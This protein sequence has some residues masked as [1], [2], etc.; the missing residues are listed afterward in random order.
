MRECARPRSTSFRRANRRSS[1]LPSCSN[2]PGWPAA[3]YSSGSAPGTRAASGRC[4]V[5]ALTDG[6]PSKT[7]SGCSS[8]PR[9]TSASWRTSSSSRREP[10]RPPPGP[11]AAGLGRPGSRPS[12]PEPMVPP[13]PAGIWLASCRPWPSTMAACPGRRARLRAKLSYTNLG[14]AIAPAEFTLSELRDLYIAALGRRVAATNLQRVLGRR[15]LLDALDR[16]RARRPSADAR[17]TC[18]A[19]AAGASRS[20]IRSPFF[21]RPQ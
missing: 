1:R 16:H 21:G 3:R 6:P 11:V 8:P 10:A 17:R 5:G 4:R 18:S 7:R 15:G 12:D 2:G 20:P 14:F 9:S 19:S 13:I